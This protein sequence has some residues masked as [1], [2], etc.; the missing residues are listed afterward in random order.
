VD[1]GT[2][3]DLS[4]GGRRLSES[5]LRDGEWA[6]VEPLVPEASP[7]GRPRKTDMRAAMK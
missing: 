1:G 2:P 4:A 7:G 5:D 3:S 6:R